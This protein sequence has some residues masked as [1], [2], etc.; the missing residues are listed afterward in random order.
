M[1]TKVKANRHIDLCEGPIFKNMI[2]YALP[3]MLSGILQ[4]LF[5][6]AD[7]AVVGKF[8]GDNAMAAVGSNGA[9]IGLITNLFIGLS[10]GANVLVAR[11]IGAQEYH[12]VQ[13]AVHTSMLVSVIGSFILMAIG[14]IGAEQFLTW[15]SCPTDVLPLAALYLRIYFLGMPAMMIYN[16]GAAILRAIGDTKRPLYFL[17]TAGVVNVLLN[18]LFVI[19]F[20]MSVTG[21]ALATVISQIISAVLVVLYLLN[22]DGP[23]R[24]FLPKLR[25][26]RTEFPQLLRIGLPAGIQSTVFALSNVVIQSSVNSFGETVVA[27]NTAGAN[28][29][30]FVY[31]AMNAFYQA[32]LAFTSQNLG[33][34]K[35]RR[36]DRTVLTGALCSVVS[37]LV[38]GIVIFLLGRPLLT[39]YTNN[40]DVIEIGMERLLYIC[41]PYLLCGL[42]EVT[43]G[44]LRGLGYSVTPMI[45]SLLGACGLRLLWIFT[46]FQIDAYHTLATIYISYPITWA[47][48]FLAHLVC[49]MIARKKI[50]ARINGEAQ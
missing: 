3:L 33:A 31:I 5:N 45:V 40:P 16:F 21:V 49:F 18:L 1:R 25:I 7:I 14:L 34:K 30:G 26:D 23:C 50:H 17:T 8:A 9:L 19:V 4:L 47:V 41:C 20:D 15:M 2:R 24:L 38:L 37:G 36:I 46:V 39:I 28:I 44:G 6:A 22:E 10:I 11:Y 12:R 32:T 48:T 29:E 43:V 42:M 27:G 35:L 13:S